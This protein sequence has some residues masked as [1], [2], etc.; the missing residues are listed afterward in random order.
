MVERRV[1]KMAACWVEKMDVELVVRK[2][3][4]MVEGM[5][6]LKADYLDMM[7]AALMAA[8]MV[9]RKVEKM[10][11]CWVEKMALYS[12]KQKVRLKAVATVASKTD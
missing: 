6:V 2:A 5:V 8:K 3:D 4:W 9:P 10:A 11:A 7:R 1:E 12:A